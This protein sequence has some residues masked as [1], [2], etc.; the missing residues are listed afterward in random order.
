MLDALPLEIRH[1]DCPQCGVH[2]DRDPQ[3]GQEHCGGWASH[4]GLWRGRQT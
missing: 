4:P 3:R 1:W 2:H